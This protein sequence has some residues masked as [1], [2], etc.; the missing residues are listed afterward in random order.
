MSGKIYFIRT[1][2]NMHRRLVKNDFHQ[3]M[4]KGMDGFSP[5]SQPYSHL[6]MAAK[7]IFQGRH[8]QDYGVDTFSLLS[9]I[10]PIPICRELLTD[11]IIYSSISNVRWYSILKSGARVLYFFSAKYCLYCPI[12]RWMNIYFSISSTG[13]IFSFT[14]SK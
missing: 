2:P 12:T 6:C 8:K 4:Y 9:S 10:Q 5:D 11:E 14:F 13:I 7:S 3:T 1:F